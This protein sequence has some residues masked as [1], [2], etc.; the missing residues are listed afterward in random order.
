MLAR[1]AGISKLR[2]LCSHVKVMPEV[3]GRRGR[4]L[5]EDRCSF[6][7]GP[8]ANSEDG[9]GRCYLLSVALFAP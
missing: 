9:S 3:Q 7:F 4:S 6:R 5:V 2:K 1:R 8:T